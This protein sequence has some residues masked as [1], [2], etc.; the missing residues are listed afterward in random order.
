MNGFEKIDKVRELVGDK[1]VLDELV[2]I[3]SYDNLDVL[4][5]DI[6]R[7]FDLEEEF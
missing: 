3:L 4:A 6:I 1:A 5:D 2:Q 7:N